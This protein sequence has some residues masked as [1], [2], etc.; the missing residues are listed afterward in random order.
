MAMSNSDEDFA[1]AVN[2]MGAATLEHIEEAKAAQAEAARNGR[3]LP[4]ADVM[5]AQ[6]LITP[7]MRESVEKR[8]K[9]QQAG[10]IQMLGQYKLLKKLGEG[11]MGAVYLAEDTIAQRQVALKVL[12]KKHAEDSE[13]IKR[14]RREAVATG[15]LNHANI[16]SAHTVGEEL[17]HHFYVM[18]YC[19]GQTLEE[20]LNR[21]KL[22]AWDWAAEIVL[23]VARGLQ[24]AHDHSF[25]H[26]DIK[27]GNIFVTS[28]GVAKILDLGMS[29]D[30]GQAAQ[31]YSTVSGMALGTP[32]YVSPEQ[33]RG[34]RKLDG[35]TDIYSLGTT[36][37]HLVTGR[38][39]FEGG[40]AAVIMAKHIN[41]QVA[42]PRDLCADVPDGVAHIIR[43]MMAK[44][45]T[46][47]YRDCRVLIADLELVLAGENPSTQAVEAEKSSV[48]ARI[49]APS[50]RRVG[51]APGPP[52]NPS[53]SA[54]APEPAEE[55]DESG[56]RPI[57]FTNMR[58]REPVAQAVSLSTKDKATAGPRAREPVGVSQAGPPVPQRAGN[59]TRRIALGIAALGGLIFLAAL[60]ASYLRE[61]GAADAGNAPEAERPADPPAT[62]P[63][64]A[65]EAK[66][67]GKT[68][69]QPAAP[70]DDS[71]RWQNAVNL[72]PL[73]NPAKH[74]LSGA[75]TVAN[76]KL[77]S[78]ETGDP[79]KGAARIEI[80]YSP[81]EEYDFRIVF[82]RTRLPLDT[83]GG[84]IVQIVSQSR[85]QLAWVMGGFG[86]NVLGF[87][88][89]N[90]ER[91]DKSAFSIK[92]ANCLQSGRQYTAVVSVRKNGAA[93]YLDGALIAQCKTH[94]RDAT[95]E[96][97]WM[98]RSTE[99][100][101]LATYGSPTVFERVEVLEVTGQG[102][103][104]E[105]NDVAVK[106]SD[107][108]RT[109]GPGP[110]TPAPPEKK[111]EPAPP[112]E[113]PAAPPI[114]F[115][116][117]DINAGMSGGTTLIEA[118]GYDVTGSGGDIWTEKDGFRF[119]SHKLSG[120]FD[121]RAHLVGIQGTHE[122]A[123]VGLMV[124]QS[125]AP[126]AVNGAVVATPGHG[127]WF[128]RRAEPGGETTQ[129]G[130]DSVRPDNAWLRLTRTGKTVTAYFGAD[131]EGR[132]WRKLIAEELQLTDTVLVG[133]CVSSHD[134][135]ALCM[136][137]FRKVTL[138]TGAAPEK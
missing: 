104:I 17:G 106:P 86:N 126:S 66:P 65:D 71:A 1:R 113:K 134:T 117:L 107:A 122:W 16:V 41:A 6:G 24:H 75:W 115:T 84:D 37:Y 121:L 89:I 15:K 96:P 102:K 12:S 72:L 30:I 23:Q 79:D 50:G 34:E 76:G 32:H 20:T 42:D 22:V 11:G 7:T 118:D 59:R 10:G 93:A 108:T 132:K 129:V 56:A 27:P 135:G 70:G 127:G 128:Q 103:I 130:D 136:G 43:K 94:Y 81:P 90:G 33:A 48:A 31:N 45:P 87:E 120:D 131:N 28:D 25:I 123:K 80:P 53:T 3:R 101:G 69:P 78:D 85:R 73:L 92:R 114:E 2:Q 4:L 68:L 40:T 91:A 98:L 5:V 9:A 14:F 88:S 64:P 67:P 19:E 39:P 77:A 52:H 62:A 133:L 57:P 74:V 116:S 21:Q 63:K 38:A 83:G 109:P 95:L 47:R 138:V 105:T 55:G 111:P 97:V 29:K 44:L 110:A 49:Q 60:V 99:L 82:T 18:E 119:V 125:K 58:V 36:F 8:L 61:R 100:L 51:R 124:R 46:D 13:F 137:K 26:R 35:R 54:H 112:P